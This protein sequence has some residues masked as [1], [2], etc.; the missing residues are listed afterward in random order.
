[1][2]LQIIGWRFKGHLKLNK[3]NGLKKREIL[4]N[5]DGGQF[6]SIDFSNK[7]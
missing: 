5:T 1:M 4:F 2:K 6:P 7:P 3:L